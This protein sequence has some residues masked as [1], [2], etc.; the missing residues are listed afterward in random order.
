MRYLR[1]FLA[2]AALS[3]VLLI[4][5]CGKS[6]FE[7]NMDVKIQ[8]FEHV[9]QNNEKVS[10]DDLK[11]KVW[12]ADLI[13]TS[14]TTVCQ[15]MTKNMADLQKMLKKEGVEDY[16]IVSFSVDPEVDTPEKLKEYISNFEVDEKKWDLLTGYEQDYIREFAEKNLQ[17][18][19]IPDP[20]SNQVTHGTSF[21]L[22]NKEG[23]AVKNYSGAEDVPFEEIVQDVKTLVEEK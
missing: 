21:Y 7:S 18:L 22:I 19:A 10:L 4:A 15:P 23:K 14:C 20:N 8:D 9:N 11:G 17:T 6:D 3:A 12:L 16:R 1:S 5:G 13:F 2:A